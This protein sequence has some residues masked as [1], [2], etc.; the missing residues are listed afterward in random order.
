MRLDDYGIAFNDFP[1]LKP[2]HPFAGWENSGRSTKSLPWYAAYNAV[3][4]DREAQ[5]ELATLGNAFAA[6]SACFIMIL[7]Q[8]GDLAYSFGSNWLGRSFFSLAS[9]PNWS[10]SDVYIRSFDGKDW[11]AV[12]FPFKK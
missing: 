3:K 6:V 9:R 10:H 7:A 5:F 8:Y 11:K 12:A 4:H 2:I 1:W